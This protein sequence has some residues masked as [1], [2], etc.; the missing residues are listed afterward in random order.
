MPTVNVLPEGKAI[1]AAEGTSLLQ[2]LLDNGFALAHKCGGN[3]SCGS[4]HLFIQEGRKSVGRIA[5]G[6][7]ALLDSI[8]GV[9]SKS[10]LACQVKLGSE[11]ISVELLSFASG[12]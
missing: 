8:P 7:N 12:R 2:A 3:L 10:R 6:E 5:P 9:G 11:D 1:Q 4:C